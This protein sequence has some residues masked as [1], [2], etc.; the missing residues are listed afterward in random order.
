M[1]GPDATILELVRDDGVAIVTLNRPERLN[2]WTTALELRYAD[3]LGELA[4]DGE[5]R[6]VVVTGAGRG[7]SAGWDMEELRDVSASGERGDESAASIAVGTTLAFPKPL[8][9]AINGSCAGLG[10]AQALACDLRFARA[11]AKLTTS[12]AKLGLI[13]EDGTSWLLPRIVGHANALDLLLSSRIV[14]AEE[15]LQLGLVHRVLPEGE[16]LSAAVRYARELATSCSPAAMAA[17]KRMLAA[18]ATA[19]VQTALRESRAMA[20]ATLAQPDF[21]EGVAAFAEKRPPRFAGL[22]TTLERTEP[23]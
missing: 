11:G 19:D 9:A 23:A 22:S 15:A 18:H 7:Y 14:L 1:S 4:A 17:I 13:A 21:G 20:L 6:A 16:L 12:Y 2:A 3:A 10:L 5:V 8:I